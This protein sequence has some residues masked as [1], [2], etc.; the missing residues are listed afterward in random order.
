MCRGLSSTN[1]CTCKLEAVFSA[2]ARL[3][4][5]SKS[6][7]I[8]S[9]I[10]NSLHW[11]PIRQRI[12]FKICSLMRNCFTGS[13]PQYLKAFCIPVSSTISRSTLRSSAMGHLVVTRT[14][15]SM[16]QSRSFATV[17]QATSDPQRRIPFANIICSVPQAPGNLPIFVSED[18]DPGRERLSNRWRYINIWLAYD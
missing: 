9:F 13:A 11:L 17:E 18:T 12:Q 3:I 5:V 15:T 8:S 1:A 16:V 14:R 2:S 6:S 10:R 7:P 4:G